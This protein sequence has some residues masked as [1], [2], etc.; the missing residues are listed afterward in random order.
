M[1][2]AEELTIRLHNEGDD[3]TEPSS[4]VLIT[5]KSTE[6]YVPGATLEAA[7]SW[8]DYFLLFMTDD[9]PY[10]EMLGVLLL[11]DKLDIV[12]S[13]TI[14]VPYSTGSFSSLHL[15]PPDRVSFHF[16]GDFTWEIELLTKPGF[17]IPF[18][19]EPRGVW[20]SLGF[21]RHFIVH[22]SPLPQDSR[23]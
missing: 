8:G 9:V 2:I 12:D 13:A 3:Q 1:R 21:K 14:G 17:R 22:G 6:K 15:S 4:E 10:E 16:I 19:S 20:R 23:T 5:G 7:V 18:F 11:D